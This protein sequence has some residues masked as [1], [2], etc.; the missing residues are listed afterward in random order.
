MKEKIES[1]K[2]WWKWNVTYKWYD[3]R[4]GIK[5]LWNYKKI[6]WG[7]GDF[8]Y[9][10]ILRM[11]K[12]Q[13]ERLLKV[14]ENGNEVD[15]DRLPKV[16]DIKRCIELIDNQL[17]DNFAERCGY[18]TDRTT[19]DFEPLDEELDGEKLYKMVNK[20]PNPQS[21]KELSTIFINARILKK[22]EW[23]ELWDII[24]KG[25]KSENGML[26]WWD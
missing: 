6:V 10:Y 25:N 13:L 2:S 3:F 4:R 5:N 11:Q 21:E 15:E 24:K 20:H 22:E 16:E 17:E 9:A 26:G 19:I 23:D 12:F 14:L 8:D 1:I 18:K 7:T